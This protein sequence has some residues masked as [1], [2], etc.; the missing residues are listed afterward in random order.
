MPSPLDYLSDGDA[1]FRKCNDR[2]IGFL[3]AKITVILQS[4]RPRQ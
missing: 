2:F 1:L 4:L 3:A